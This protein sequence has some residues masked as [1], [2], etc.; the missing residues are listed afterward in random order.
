MEDGETPEQC[1]AREFEEEIGAAVRVGPILDAWVY[2]VLPGRR[3]FIVA[4]AVVRA[5]A[6]PLTVSAEHQQMRWWPLDAL[7]GA[8]LPEGYRRAIKFARYSV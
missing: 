2:E 8:E 6:G 7:P 3:V 5:L 4:Y 1:V